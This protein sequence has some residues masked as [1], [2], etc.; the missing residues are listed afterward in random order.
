M[1]NIL[2]V[3]MKQDRAERK[4]KDLFAAAEQPTPGLTSSELVR[5]LQEYQTSPTQQQLER[6]AVEYDADAKLL[7]GV[8]K[9]V[10]VPERQP[11]QV[12]EDR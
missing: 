9:W 12:P 10:R 3:R 5:L 7:E 11:M 1:L 6:L 2:D 4:P 8:A